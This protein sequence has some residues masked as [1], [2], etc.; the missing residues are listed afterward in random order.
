MGTLS[1]SRDSKERASTPCC[2]IE[3]DA[4]GGRLWIMGATGIGIPVCQQSDEERV[5]SGSS[6]PYSTGYGPVV[7][8]TCAEKGL[9]YC[10]AGAYGWEAYLESEAACEKMKQ[11]LAEVAAK[12]PHPPLKSYFHACAASSNVVSCPNAD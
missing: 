7:D 2:S 12:P 11:H 4:T 1:D 10:F 8:G 9:S 6:P 5:C 3:T